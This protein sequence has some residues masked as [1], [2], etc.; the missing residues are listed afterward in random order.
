MEMMGLVRLDTE[1]VNSM[2]AVGNLFFIA[3]NVF[4]L[5]HP[6]GETKRR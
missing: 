1:A 4:G 5:A 6:K 3:P 2:G